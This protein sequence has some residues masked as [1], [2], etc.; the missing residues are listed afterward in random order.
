MNKKLVNI[1]IL[2]VRPSSHDSFH[3]FTLTIHVALLLNYRVN[4]HTRSIRQVH[5]PQI[6]DFIERVGFSTKYK[7]LKKL[8]RK[9]DKA[10]SWNFELSSFINSKFRS[11]YQFL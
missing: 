8:F 7:F 10:H 11:I 5:Q 1:C 4:K 3:M 2:Y 9:H 6:N